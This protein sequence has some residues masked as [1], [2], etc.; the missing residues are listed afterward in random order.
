VLSRNFVFVER[1][2]T[3]TASRK[4]PLAR[5][6]GRVETRGSQIGAKH[7][8]QAHRLE[9]HRDQT[10]K[11]SEPPCREG[12]KMRSALGLTRFT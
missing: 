11:E 12:T 4:L 8:L 10:I 7:A 1:P 3:G 6:Y 9:D 5:T 2:R